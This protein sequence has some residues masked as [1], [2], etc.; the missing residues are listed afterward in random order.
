ML[1]K[2]ELSLIFRAT[3]KTD[4]AV[5]L[6][7]DVA[8]KAVRK[9]YSDPEDK[10]EYARVLFQHVADG[11]KSPIARF[12]RTCGLSVTL[13]GKRDTLSMI[14]S[15]VDRTKQAKLFERLDDMNAIILDIED[16]AQKTRTAPDGTVAE[17][18]DKKIK[19]L[20]SR[21]SKDKVNPF[22]K[23]VAALINQR[24]QRPAWMIKLEQLGLNESEVQAV[25][26]Y[27]LETRMMA[28]FER[29]AA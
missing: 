12:F 13:D 25:V 21:V 10:G 28:T 17:Q 15:V 11:L 20:I 4:A 27:V 8:R 26:E 9:A 14:G 3:E 2:S 24:L 19:D 7:N 16:Y 29:K 23:E 18:A 22:A 1:S 6:L 5:E